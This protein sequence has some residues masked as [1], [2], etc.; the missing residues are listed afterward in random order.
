MRAGENF[1]LCKFSTIPLTMFARFARGMIRSD[2]IRFY[3]LVNFGRNG[4]IK[5]TPARIWDP[6]LRGEQRE[7]EV[8]QKI[9]S[10]PGGT[11]TCSGGERDG[12]Y[13]TL[14]GLQ[15]LFILCTG[16]LDTN[17]S[18]GKYVKLIS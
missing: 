15:K 17:L 10:H 16:L 12:H 2:R 4:F 9:F 6:L 13:A 14:P 5:S 11:Q 18:L 7:A 3:I 8:N 1:F